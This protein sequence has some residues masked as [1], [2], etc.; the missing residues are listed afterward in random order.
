MCAMRAEV[1]AEVG[2][3]NPRLKQTEE[4][5]YG[6]RLSRRYPIRLSSAVHGRHDHDADLRTLLRKL[7]HRG[8]AR[9][10][11]YAQ[12]RQFAR[13]FETRARVWGCLA[14]L[15]AVAT[16]W[17]PLAFGPVWTAL[18]AG[19]LAASIGSDAGMYRFVLSRRGPAFVGYFAAVHLLV[20]VTIAVAAGTGVLQW[21]VSDRFRRLYDPAEPAV[22]EALA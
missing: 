14:A 20:N 13:G 11:L 21:L 22:Q 6:Y 18:P 16:A 4:V 2:Q 1:F 17:L 19:L 10:P 7:F 12:A 8:R 5:D 9:V 3:F 15:F